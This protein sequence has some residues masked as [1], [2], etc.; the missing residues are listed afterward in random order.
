MDRH[1]IRL[2]RTDSVNSV[3]KDNFL[4][5]ELKNTFK[6]L[7][8]NDIKTTVDQYERFMVERAECENYRVILTINPYCT[9]VLFNPFTE[10]VRNEGSDDVEDERYWSNEEIV[11]GIDGDG[12]TAKRIQMIANTEYSKP[13]NKKDKRK[14]GYTYL[15]GYDI[16]DN[17]I[18][19]NLGFNVVEKKHR[20]NESVFNTLADFERSSDGSVVKMYKRTDIEQKPTKIDK[21]L[22]TTDELMLFEDSVNANLTDE[23]GWFGFINASNL[24]TTSPGEDGVQSDI[25]CVINNRKNCEFIEMYPDSTLFSFSPKY[26]GFRRRLEQNWEV[27]LTYA[28]ENDY[29]NKLVKDNSLPILSV[30]KKLGLTGEDIIVFRSFTKHNLKRGD[31]VKIIYNEKGVVDGEPNEDIYRVANLGNASSG[32]SD[33]YFYVNSNEF[34]LDIEQIENVRFRK[35]YNGMESKYYVRKMK[36]IGNGQ[37]FYDENVERY[38]LAFADTIYGDDTT[39]LTFTDTINIK[40]LTDNLGRP[41][42]EIYVTIVKTNYGNAEWYKQNDGKED[43]N[44]SNEELEKIEYSHCFGDVTCGYVLSHENNDQFDFDVLTEREGQRDIRLINNNQKF[45]SRVP[46]IVVKGDDTEFDGDVVEFSPEDCTEHVIAEC[47]FRFNTFQREHPTVREFI[48]HELSYD[49][50]DVRDF[51]VSPKRVNNVQSRDEGYYYKAHY[52]MKIRGFGGINQMG[53][54]EIK[55]VDVHPV[56]SSNIALTVKSTIPTKLNENDIVYLCD[57]KNDFMFEF[58]CIKVESSVR[59]RII[60]KHPSDEQDPWAYFR[61]K[62]S[63]KYT[64]DVNINWVN[65]SELIKKGEFKLR[66]KNYDIP[67]YAFKMGNNMYMW[68]ETLDYG[69]ISEDEVPEYTFANNAFYLTPIIRFYLKR[70]DPDN[71]VRLYAKEHFPNDIFGNIKKVSN[72]YYEEEIDN[73]C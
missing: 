6:K 46:Q 19:R 33:Y 31:M 17:H 15:P 24:R 44:L 3:N 2:G 8:Y 7:H 21:H 65:L 29:C 42:S 52:P 32:N 45:N 39:Q 9:N 14:S 16:F 58:V 68:R 12:S 28:A 73:G 41:L 66:G 27:F 53:N 37:N 47:A 50:Y 38:K 70:Q 4:G 34:D 11:D 48:Y 56:R 1:Q 72:Y 63:E 23:N 57:D 62:I 13:Y 10:V 25:C 71:T 43:R 35:I 18:I 30:E 69:E 40:G 5:V 60:P 67:D 54:N 64:D 59:F 49:D 51:A 20:G 55:V 26:N 61:E 36:R 22:Y